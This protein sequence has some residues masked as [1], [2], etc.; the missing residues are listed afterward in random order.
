MIQRIQS[1]FL[2]IMALTMLAFLFVP[3]W[4]K[5]DVDTQEYVFLNAFR[6]SYED[7]SGVMPKVLAT[8]NTIYISILAIVSAAVSLFSIFQYKNRLTQMK[9]GALNSLLV[10][11][12][13]AA[14]YVAITKGTN[15]IDPSLPAEFKIGFF[16]PVVAL[17]FNSLANRFIR[18]DE[19]LVRDS[20]RMR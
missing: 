11:G 18:R 4:V 16:L 1:V 14:S 7:H 12:V 10:G 9:L 17:I 20:E 6:L 19:K 13:V 5:G 3:I 8:K 2:L 15:L